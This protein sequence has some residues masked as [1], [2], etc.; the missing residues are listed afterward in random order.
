MLAADGAEVIVDGRNIVRAKCVADYINLNNGKAAIFIGDLTSNEGADAV[1][2]E[3]HKN[4]K[5][6]IQ[7]AAPL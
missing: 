3:A 7:G 4:G 6:D 2:K 1:I 5:I